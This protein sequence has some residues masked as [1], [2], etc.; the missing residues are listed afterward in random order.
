MD[1]PNFSA[2]AVITH[3]RMLGSSVLFWSCTGFRETDSHGPVESGFK[4]RLA[5][6]TSCSDSTNL[7]LAMSG[8]NAILAQHDDDVVIVQAL[9]TAITKVSGLRV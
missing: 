3:D 8:K 2:T 1:A 4:R 7:A 9:R 5:F 6:P